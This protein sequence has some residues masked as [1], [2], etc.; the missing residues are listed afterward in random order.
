VIEL[1]PAADAA[2]AIKAR[3]ERRTYL[4]ERGYS[5]VDVA[6]AEVEADVTKVLNGLA[7]VCVSSSSAP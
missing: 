2:E 7:S 3:A 1:V 6:M 5:V 4:T